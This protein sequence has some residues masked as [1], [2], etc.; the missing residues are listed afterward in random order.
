LF[1]FFFFFPFFFLVVWF[2]SQHFAEFAGLF[3]FSNRYL[4]EIWPALTKHLAQW[5]INCKLDLIEGSMTVL[6]TRKTWDP[7]AILKV[8]IV[9]F[10]FFLVAT[11]Q[12]CAFAELTFYFSRPEI[13]SNFCQEAFPINRLAFPFE[14]EEQRK[15]KE[16][17]SY[18]FLF[19]KGYQNHARRNELRHYQDWK[20]CQKQRTI[21][22]TTTATD[23]PKRSDTEG[24]RVA[25][26]LL[27]AG[28]GKHCGSDGGLASP[29]A[30]APNCRRL[31]SQHPPNLQY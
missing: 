26:W 16:R 1:F 2:F 11:V 7:Y 23:W 12:L 17:K 19:W 24:Y 22:E 27:C 3:F 8:C 20:H 29:E 28:S 18:S 15:K 10:F 31:S 21:R 5:G 13:S 6:T 9:A 30:S 4:R 14:R 25:N